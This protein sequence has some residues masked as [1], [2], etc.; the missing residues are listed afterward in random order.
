[1]PSLAADLRHALDRAAFAHE[2]L[3]LVPDDWQRRV[4][5]SDRH[6]I[7]L[8]CSRQSGKSTVAAV[9]ALHQ[10]IY[11]PSSLVLLVSPSLRQ[12]GELFRKVTAGLDRLTAAP[13]RDEDSSLSFRLANGSRVVSLPASETTVRGYSNVALVV[14]DEA[15]FVADGLYTA[16][17]P[18]LAVSGGRLILMSTPCGRRGHFF[19]EWTDGGDAWERTKITAYD[20]SRISAEFLAEEQRSLGAWRFAQEYLGEFAEDDAQLFDFQTI[21][22]AL[23]GDVMPLFE[24]SCHA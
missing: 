20:V 17:R 6:R 2:A 11:F 9:L 24:G 8:N 19:A 13:K 15:A 18:M 1:M 7:L 23:S 4:L 14:E 12:S 22:A 3:G 10:A 5:R 21:R 16:V